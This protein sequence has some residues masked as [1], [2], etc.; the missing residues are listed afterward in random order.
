[1]GEKKSVATFKLRFKVGRA[2]ARPRPAGNHD[3]VLF[4][5]GWIRANT[6]IKL[7]LSTSRQRLLSAS[8]ASARPSQSSKSAFIAGPESGPHSRGSL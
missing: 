4:A 7:L 2:V 6:P 1:M 3:G 5:S 8:V